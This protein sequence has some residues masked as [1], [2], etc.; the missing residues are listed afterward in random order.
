[1]PARP[2]ISNLG[3]MGFSVLKLGENIS[4]KWAFS[5]MPTEKKTECLYERGRGAWYKYICVIIGK[6]SGQIDHYVVI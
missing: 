5:I 3:M 2:K 1:M 6:H 4:V